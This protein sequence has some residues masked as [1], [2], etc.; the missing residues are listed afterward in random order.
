MAPGSWL[1][2]PGSWLL[3]PGSW[4]LAP[5][6]PRRMWHGNHG[7]LALDGSLRGASLQTGSIPVPT[8]TL[9]SQFPAPEANTGLTDPGANSDLRWTAVER[10]PDSH[11]ASLASPWAGWR[12]R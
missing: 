1:M 5:M 8:Q 7:G 6:R 10:H 11:L 2:A 9:F 12:L 4:L 3:A